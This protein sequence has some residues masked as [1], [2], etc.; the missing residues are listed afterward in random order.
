MNVNFTSSNRLFGLVLAGGQSSRMGKDKGS[1]IYH[2][3][4]QRE[5]LANLMQPFCE[6]VFISCRKEQAI[7]SNHDL[8]FDNYENVGPI[9]ALLTA[10]EFNSEVSWLVIACDLPF[11]DENGIEFLIK[12]RSLAQIATVFQ[13]PSTLEVEPLS[14]IWENSSYDILKKYFEKGFR[15]PKRVLQKNDV[16]LLKPENEKI[17]M[18]VNYL[19]EFEAIKTIREQKKTP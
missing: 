8:L 6:K 10:F 18:N 12:N 15:S 16:K 9:G 14:A 1:L 5:Y 13:H 11:M 19:K 7:I 2:Q 4:P 17:L 3:E